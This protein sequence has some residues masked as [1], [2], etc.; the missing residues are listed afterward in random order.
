MDLN[1]AA[2]MLL[3][4]AINVVTFNSVIAVFSYAYYVHK[5]HA[6][7]ELRGQ[8]QASLKQPV[9]LMFM[10]K[11]SHVERILINN[12]FSKKDLDEYFETATEF[13]IQSRRI[14]AII[15]SLVPMLAFVGVFFVP[16]KHL[17]IQYFVFLGVSV[18]TLVASIRFG[19]KLIPMSRQENDG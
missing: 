2:N 4:Y 16:E 9:K 15:I 1:T 19:H 11:H 8:F 18:T 10:G 7:M 17:V 3:L 6:S 12:M 5:V 13:G 14:A